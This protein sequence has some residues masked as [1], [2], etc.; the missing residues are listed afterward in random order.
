MEAGANGQ[1]A[2][3]SQAPGLSIDEIGLVIFIIRCARVVAFLQRFAPAKYLPPEEERIPPSLLK[4]LIHELKKLVP[5]WKWT[6]SARALP[7]SP[8]KLGDEL[9]YAITA[10]RLSRAEISRA[11][12]TDCVDVLDEVYSLLY[13]IGIRMRERKARSKAKQVEASE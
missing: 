2:P 11:G 10:L 9:F 6:S 12:Y 4:R 3:S 5:K 7:R 1:D 8:A 13:S